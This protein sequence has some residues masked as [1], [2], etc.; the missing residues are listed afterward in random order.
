MPAANFAAAVGGAAGDVV[1]AGFGE[2]AYRSRS[3]STEAQLAVVAVQRALDDAGLSPGGVDGIIANPSGLGADDV[4]SSFSLP[5]RFAATANL[6]GASMVASLQLA[7][8][9]LRSGQANAVLVFIARKGS[10]GSRISD[11]AVHLPGQFFRTQLEHP[12]GWSTPAQWYAMIC[13]RHMIEYGTTKRQLAEVAL[14]MRRHSAL[15]ERA[16]LHHRRLS[17]EDYDGAPLIADPYQLY[18]CCLE[19]DGAAAVL[20]TTSERA[21]HLSGRSVAL[22]AIA[23]ARP[24]S[25]DDLTN[26]P[27]WFQIGL[28]D[29]APRA[30]AEAG[31]A[32]E[33]MDA[34]MIYDCFTFEVL[35]Q[36]EEAGFCPAGE[37][38]P[39]VM[40]GHIGL[41][42]KLPV[43][44][45]GGLMAEGHLNGLNHVIEA[46]RQ[47]RGEAGRR[48][49]P[50]L[51]H[52]AVTGW[53]NLGDGALAILRGAGA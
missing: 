37:S 53:G 23:V 36:L 45:H 2:T 18:D 17:L 34:A 10:S 6:G 15:N 49:L 35:H 4:V 33:D 7:T 16:Q 39:F 38:G 30:F 20:L 12:Y 29:A 47:L 14:T 44:P 5:I 48:Q 27:N 3:E 42:G 26:R 43:N 52:I 31:L 50:N 24:E 28:S 9:A 8:A 11:R 21:R 1:I 46:V 41:D 13:R 19:T 32:P 40:A 25:P 51:R 22:A